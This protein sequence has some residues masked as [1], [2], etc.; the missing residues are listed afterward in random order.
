MSSNR[1]SENAT[2]PLST[3]ESKTTPSFTIEA[4]KFV[5]QRGGAAEARRYSWTTATT[6]RFGE[7]R[8]RG[9]VVSYADGRGSD[10]DFTFTAY[11]WS[12]SST[13]DSRKGTTS[14]WS[15]YTSSNHDVSFVFCIRA[16]IEKT[17]V[18]LLAWGQRF[19]FDRYVFSVLGFLSN[20]GQLVL[21]SVD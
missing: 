17:Q 13:S 8:N 3:S 10:D 18:L 6:A 20:F 7:L 9:G 2:A 4:Y 19:A 16:C 12:S 11:R 1:N 21:V 5:K 14:C 15:R